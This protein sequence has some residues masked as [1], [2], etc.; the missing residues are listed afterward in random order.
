MHD[1]IILIFL[2]AVELLLR[3]LPIV[4]VEKLLPILAERLSQSWHLQ[5]YLQWCSQ[6]LSQYTWSLKDKS[7]AMMSFITDLQKSVIQK[8]NDLGKLLVYIYPKYYLQLVSI[9]R[10]DSNTYKIEYAL[11]MAKLQESSPEMDLVDTR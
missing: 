2:F 5:F 10:C 11:A 7:S 9:F 8:Q 6:L 4:Y 1:E 3:G